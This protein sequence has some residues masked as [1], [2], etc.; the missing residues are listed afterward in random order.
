MVRIVTHP[1]KDL[2]ADASAQG[3]DSLG[4]GVTCG[5]P[6]V[7]VIAASARTLELG[8]GDAME[9]HVELTVA[10]TTE[11]VSGLVV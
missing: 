4:L 7:E 2:V 10:A 3:S 11:A 6:F 9:G 1:T 5:H 8:H